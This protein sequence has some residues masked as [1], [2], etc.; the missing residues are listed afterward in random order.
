M[1]KKIW[2]ISLED[3]FLFFVQ[4]I[5]DGNEGCFFVLNRPEVAANPIWVMGWGQKKC[6]KFEDKVFPKFCTTDF[7]GEQNNV[8]AFEYSMD[9]DHLLLDIDLELNLIQKQ[10]IVEQLEAVKKIELKNDLKR[11]ASETKLSFMEKVQNIQKFES[12]GN[13]WVV[14][15]TQNICGDLD[16][17]SRSQILLLL[18]AYFDFLQSGTL[19]CGGVM[20]TEDQRFCSFSPEVFC[21]QDG[22]NISGYPIKGTGTK[23]ELEESGK[24]ISELSMITDL[25]R[26]DFGQICTKVSVLNERCLTREADFYHTHSV[27]G[28]DLKGGRLDW[29]SFLSLMPA[30][31]ISGAPKRKVV[32]KIL[33]LENFSRKFYT[34][35]FGVQLSP[36]FS[37]FNILIRTLFVGEKHWYF[38]V[39]AG[40]TVESDPELEFDET[41]E[42]AKVFDQFCVNRA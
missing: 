26:N 22:G 9:S 35:T 34:G 7:L 27:I 23:T 25:L 17:D 30:G 31:S 41:F 42:K 1:K 11:Y 18:S 3:A 33:E 21:K 32:E 40:I 8:W 36:D 28:G 39:G 19:H 2:G 20:A 16:L 6:A 37:V 12:D 5:M 14:N 38:P 13:A 4:K 24:E 15:L 29:E 10:K